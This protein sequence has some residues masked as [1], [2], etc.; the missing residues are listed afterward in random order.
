MV[1]AEFLVRGA[2]RLARSFGISP[3][4]VG[5]TVVAFGTSSPELAVSVSGALAGGAG[6]DVA[7]GNVVG[8]NIFNVLFILGLSA[9][10][11]PLV[12][13]RRL[14]WLDVPLMIVVSLAAW[15]FAA[16][17]TI[18]RWEGLILFAGIVAYTVHAIRSAR[19]ERTAVAPAPADPAAEAGS[20]SGG[21]TASVVLVIAGLVV[22]VVGSQWLV[23]GAVAMAKGLGVSE[24]VISLTI[25]AAGTSLP[26]VATSVLAS[27]RGERDIAVGNVVGSNIFNLLCVLG[28]AAAVAPNGITVSPAALQFDVPVMA[29]VALACLPIFFTG[30]RIARGEGALFLAYYVAYVAFLVLSATQHEALPTF[31]TAMLWFAAPLTVLTI[32]IGVARQLRAPRAAPPVSAGPRDPSPPS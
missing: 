13:E 1:G 11:T 23:D 28:G 16:D 15:L 32:G 26:E 5:L 29:A 6:A 24:L 30:H 12:V 19:K 21:L 8:S 9:L 4:V 31:G 3:L 27:L 14:V 17:G 7:L 22:L 25:V 18:A 20:T 2:S 10:L